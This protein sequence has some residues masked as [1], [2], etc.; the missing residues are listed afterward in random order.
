M[1]AISLSRLGDL[2]TAPPGRRGPR[3]FSI[4]RGWLAARADDDWSTRWHDGWIEIHLTIVRQR[5]KI[6]FC[7]DP[8]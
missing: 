7:A 4:G 6:S 8:P 3:V 2:Y 5:F 1:N